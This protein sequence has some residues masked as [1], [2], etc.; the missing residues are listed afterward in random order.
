MH[1]WKDDSRDTGSGCETM[2]LR[3]T[4]LNRETNIIS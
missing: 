1:M 4:K 2:H 3:Y